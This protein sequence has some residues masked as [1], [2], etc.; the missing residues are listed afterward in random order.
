MPWR[1][2][3][4][5]YESE[6]LQLYDI[7]FSARAI[8]DILKERY[9]ITVCRNTVRNFI[10][11][12]RP[13]RHHGET[14]KMMYQL[15]ILQRSLIYPKKAFDKPSERS[16]YCGFSED[17][18]VRQYGWQ[19]F[20]SSGSTHPSFIEL[21]VKLFRPY[22][23]LMLRSTFN[24]RFNVFQLHFTALLHESFTF[25]VDYKSDRIG[26]LSCF[27]RQE[28]LRYLE[29]LVDSE[30][31]LNIA[32]VNKKDYYYPVLSISNTNHEILQWLEDTFGG[33]SYDYLNRW[34]IYGKE[35]LTLLK[36]LQL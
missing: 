7:G 15:G 20:I 5:P 32:R 3:L 26:T 11:Q 27:N 17:F 29:G 19:T 34:Q 10:L 25:L 31:S 4:E 13:L 8:R 28:R 33:H 22:G 30:G 2:K 24:D 1:S 9:G 6:I 36:K 35:A 23:R 21:S 18:N 12:R 14:K 16:Y